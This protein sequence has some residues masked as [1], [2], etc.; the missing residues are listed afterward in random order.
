MKVGKEK[1]IKDR[2]NIGT[3]GYLFYIRDADMLSC[4]GVGKERTV[5]EKADIGT[6]AFSF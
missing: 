5:K 2:A 6:P 1:A 4:Q 3:L